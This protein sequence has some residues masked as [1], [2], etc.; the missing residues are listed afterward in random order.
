[1]SKTLARKSCITS[2]LLMAAA[3]LLLLSDAEA[4]EP[5]PDEGADGV[6]DSIREEAA[7]M[8]HISL[9]IFSSDIPLLPRLA[10]NEDWMIAL[11]FFKQGIQGFESYAVAK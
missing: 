2:S 8:H 10:N 9:V 5:S 6:V 1:M 3:L 11:V 7:G 4:Q